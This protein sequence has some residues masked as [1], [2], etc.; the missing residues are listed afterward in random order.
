MLSICGDAQN[1]GHCSALANCARA[2]VL[3]LDGTCQPRPFSCDPAGPHVTRGNRNSSLQSPGLVKVSEGFRVSLC[4]P[5]A[6]HKARENYRGIF[7]PLEYLTLTQKGFGKCGLIFITLEMVPDFLSQGNPPGFVITPASE[8]PEPGFRSWASIAY[9][10][11]VSLCF[12]S[13]SCIW[14]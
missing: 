3:D 1:A 10:F 7:S 13:P 12:W 6:L 2:M 4:S 14:E 9:C 11:P 8:H 5:K